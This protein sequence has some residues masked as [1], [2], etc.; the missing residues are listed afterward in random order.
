[1]FSIPLIIATI[2]TNA[3]SLSEAVH[4]GRL[5]LEFDIEGVVTLPNKRDS[6]HMAVEDAS[7]G[8]LLR[9]H[10][11]KCDTLFFKPGE[12]LRMRGT[13][14]RNP[15]GTVYAQCTQ[16]V[17]TAVQ[18]APIPRPATI[19]SI[20]AGAFNDRLVEVSGRV[21]E[22][23]RDEVDPGWI[24]MILEH[25]GS[26]IAVVFKSETGDISPFTLMT[27]ATVS[28]QGFC[29]STMHGFRRMIG[30]HISCIGPEAIRVVTPA[31][32][33]PFAVPPIGDESRVSPFDVRRMGRRRMNGRVVAVWSDRNFLLEDDVGNCHRVE[34][35]SN[36][37]PAY[38]ARVEV[39]GF[40]STDLYSIHLGGGLWRPATNAAFTAKQAVPTVL[41]LDDFHDTAF[42]RI[43]RFLKYNGRDTRLKGPVVSIELGKTR[44]RNCTIR[45]EDFNVNVNS[46]TAGDLPEDLAIG[47]V[48]DVTGTCVIS[49]G[50][51]NP[52]TSFPHIEDSPTIVLRR[53]GD[54]K[55]IASPP[56]W[57]PLRLMVAIGILLVLLAAILLWAIALKVVA[58]RRGRQLFQTEIGRAEE[59]LRVG[60]RT[61]L[62][63]EL[64]DTLAQNLTGAAFQIEAA[65]DATEPES[66]AVSYLTCAEQILKSCRTEL[67]RCIWDLKS[68][69]LEAPDLN[70]AILATIRPIVGNA[71]V[72][73]RFN[74]PR[75][76]ISDVTAHA[77]LRIIRE[78]VA[79][80]VHHGH[81]TRIRIAGEIV[82][83]HLHFSVSDNGC[84]F[85][86]ESCPGP[87]TGHFGLDGIRER[88]D[89]FGGTLEIASEPGNGTKATATIGP[90]RD[91]LSKTT[92]P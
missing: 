43:T 39:V 85:N 21:R 12:R 27:D 47:S 62:A 87:S 88:I 54:M 23:F 66:E 44:Y 65:K 26:R 73:I 60:E 58:E 3:A 45:Y 2:L 6:W 14:A 78:L 32:A 31:P 55:I 82:D 52:S 92:R 4:D 22:V 17:V 1:M 69:A 10:S 86:L 36:G 90:A 19:S 8:V 34:L 15:I 35:I 77:L 59:T 49:A 28:V 48:V 81:A 72:H 25:D 74:V 29:T 50:T 5:G 64:H 51:W 38:D 70:T 46:G 16:A 76:R 40:P 20:Y 57:T 37:P 11:P 33:D 67:R 30:R 68:N 42:G 56:W 83:E 80:A 24:Y 89:T 79:N 71:D 63:V 61:R 18:A 84:G 53:P 7:G 13:T 75:S 9:N 41:T 91:G